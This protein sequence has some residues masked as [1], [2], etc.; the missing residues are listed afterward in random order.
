MDTDKETATATSEPR[1]DAAVARRAAIHGALSDPARLRIVGWITLATGQY[2]VR[3]QNTADP[4]YANFAALI[5]T[6]PSA[7]PANGPATGESMSSSL[8]RNLCR[9]S[10]SSGSLGSASGNAA[11][12]MRKADAG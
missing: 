11:P 1:N 10:G 12:L 8:V 4:A 3:I 5:V 7:N 2:V 6:N 9:C